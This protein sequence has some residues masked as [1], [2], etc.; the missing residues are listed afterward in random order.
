MKVSVLASGSKG[1]STYIE[2]D[3]HKYLVDLGTTSTY[4]EKKLKELKID[5]KEIDGIFLTHT[6]VDHISGLRVFIKRYHPELY[7]SQ[8]MYDELIKTYPDFSYTIIDKYLEVDTFHVTV[9]K[10]SHDVDDSNGYLFE[11]A[12]SSIVYITDTGYLNQKYFSMLKNRSIY[13]ME[14][15]HDINLLMNGSYPYH[16]KQRILGD[17]G[18]LSNIDSSYYLSKLIGK[19]TEKIIL[20]HLSE[21]NNDET[22][23]YDTCVEK[24]PYPVPV[25]VSRQKEQTELIEV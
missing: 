20:I 18:H 8:I 13:I 19:N 3:H 9:F 1:N 25:I 7:V 15:N 12:D 6:H 10:T 21:E 14:S 11:E 2:T 24:I 4:V 17:R 23:A 5:P 16:L 22:I